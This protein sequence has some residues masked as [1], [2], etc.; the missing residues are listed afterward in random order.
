M[1]RRVKVVMAVKQSSTKNNRHNTLFW[2]TLIRAVLVFA[3]GLSLLLITEKTHPMLY[4]FMGFF[5]LMSG[6]I[7]IREEIHLKEID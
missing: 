1:F 4:N 6:I 2:I 3:L 7:L 5:W